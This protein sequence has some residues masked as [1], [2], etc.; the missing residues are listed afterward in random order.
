M[1]RSIWKGAISFGLVTIP[2]K[3][4]GATE[5]KDISFRQIHAEDQGR[6][7]YKRVCEKCGEEIDYASIAKGYEAPDGRLA[8][9][10]KEDFEGLPLATTKAV[11]VVQFV[12]AA[13]IDPI[14]YDKPY[15]LEAD[16]PGMKPYVLLRDALKKAGK[17]AVVKVALRSR[18]SIALIRVVDDVLLLQTLLWPDEVRDA[19]FAAPPDEIRVSDAEVAMASMFIDQ[20][21]GEFDAAAHTDAY[22]EALE[23]VVEAKLSGVAI[24]EEA[25]EAPKQAEVV[26]LVAALRASVEAAKKRR[27]E[28]QGK[29][30][31]ATGKKAG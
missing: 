3:V 27:D 28:E 17:A 10:D 16:G 6:I 30:A 21:S 5:Q 13:T 4:Y 24:A 25:G 9:L 8:I 19:G 31:A 11:E 22:R 20:M 15:Y 23:K 14:M 7:K 2:I 12:E 26:D 29:A 1:P 18:E